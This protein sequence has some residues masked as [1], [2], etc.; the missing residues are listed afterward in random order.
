MSTLSRYSK[1]HNPFMCLHTRPIKQIPAN[2]ATVKDN[3]LYKDLFVV[4]ETTLPSSVRIRVLHAVDN[5]RA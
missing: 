5:H 3:Y 4:C 1:S 2:L